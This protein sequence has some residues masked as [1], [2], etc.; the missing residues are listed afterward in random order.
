LI[1]LAANDLPLK[2][3]P[4]WLSTL[5]KLSWLAIAGNDNVHILTEDKEEN[6]GVHL[7]NWEDLEI[8]E[9]LGEG[10]SGIIY[11]AKYLRY[12]YMCIYMYVHIYVYTYI[13]I[14]IYVYPYLYIHINAIP[15]SMYYS[16]CYFTILQL[17]IIIIILLGRIVMIM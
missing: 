4:N 16:I 8:L 6:K 17:I 11:K 12:I 7:I 10:A 9:K 15:T 3:L 13:V 14:Y 5:P 1:R 2:G